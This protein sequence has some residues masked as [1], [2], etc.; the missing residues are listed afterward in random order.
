MLVITAELWPGGDKTRRRTIGEMLIANDSELAPVSSYS[1][2]IFQAADPGSG[3]AAW[4]STLV[5]DRHC[6]ADGV[7]A[8][9]C[10]I[11]DQALSATGSDPSPTKKGHSDV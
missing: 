7:W 3:A 6:R 1:V 11:L 9:V 8:L 5:V 4:R 10:A 2:A